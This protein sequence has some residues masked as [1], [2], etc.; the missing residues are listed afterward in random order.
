MKKI[1][2]FILAFCMLIPLAVSPAFA[3]V[4]TAEEFEQLKQQAEAGDAKA[5]EE[6]AN[7]YYR[8]SFN[9]GISRDFN[10]ALEWFLR[11]A[12]AGNKDVYLTIATIY[13]K[14]SAGGRDLEKAYEWYQR[15]AED[16][17]EEAA[18]ATQK[19]MYDNLHWKD[20]IYRLTGKLGE[21]AS[22][23]G[24]YGTP[25][26]LDRPVVDCPRVALQM[27]F[28]EY[29]G[30]PFGLYGLYAMTMNGSWVELGRFQIEKFQAEEGAEPRMYSFDLSAPQSFKALGV[31]L[32][33]DGMDFNL[34][35]ADEFY[36]DKSCVSDYSDAVPAPVFNPSGA[37]YPENS[38]SV[39]Y[40]AWVN[41]YPS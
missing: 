15:A 8:G 30:W 10:Q 40:T 16:G 35:H 31:V 41:P 18:E 9:A 4:Q 37:E 25:F 27:S 3:A 26:Y 24:R 36:V 20:N 39:T 19:G 6:V 13:E 21:F 1:L 5:M 11:A 17:S 34:K 12:D 7:T 33:E 2:C 32:L 38:A 14:G 23:G 22:L 28:V 29:R